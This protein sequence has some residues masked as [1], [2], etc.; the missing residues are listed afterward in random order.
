MLHNNQVLLVF[1]GLCFFWFVNCNR[2]KLN[3]TTKETKEEK[4]DREE[5]FLAQNFD[6]LLNQYDKNIRPNYTGKPIVVTV[7][8]TVMAFGAINE[9]GMTFATDLYFRQT[10]QDYRLQHKAGTV[11]TPL[12]GRKIPTDFIWTP[13]TVISNSVKTRKHKVTTNNEKLDIYP[14]GTVFW[15]SR[16]TVI[17]K[18]KMDFRNYPMDIQSCSLVINSYAYLKE[19]LEYK[20]K[21]DKVSIQSEEMAQYTVKSAYNLRR[22]A[23]FSDLGTFSELVVTFTFA[24][25]ISVTI[26]QLFFPA[27]AIVSVSWVSLWIHKNCVSARVALC[28]TTMLTICAFWGSVNRQLPRVNYPKAVDYYF[29]VSFLF[30]MLTLVEFTIVLNF[31]FDSLKTKSVKKQSGKDTLKRENSLRNQL[32]KHTHHVLRRKISRLD[33]NV[34]QGDLVC[35]IDNTGRTVHYSLA[36]KEQWKKP[37]VDKNKMPYFFKY[38]PVTGKPATLD[39]IARFLFPFVYFC[40]NVIF[41]KT[42]SL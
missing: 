2:P 8:L 39:V 7:D 6:H 1:M 21:Q 42:Y 41:W 28:V 10:W 15:G 31:D 18:C 29:I 27:T 32:P 25:Q 34:L 12:L 5:I 14:N 20:W 22:N 36:K 33:A 23:N 4:I 38:Y 37:K 11:L 13:D 17:S 35:E 24:R 26:I 19:H 40:F 3:S 9:R 30:I 16:I